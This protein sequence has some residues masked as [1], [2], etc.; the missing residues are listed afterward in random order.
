MAEATRG[1]VLEGVAFQFC[2]VATVALIAG[3][4]TLPISSGLCAALFLAAYLNGKRDTRCRLRSPLLASAVYAVVCVG[5][6]WWTF[7]K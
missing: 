2:K 3:R 6:L 4:W 7:R 5:S 1:A